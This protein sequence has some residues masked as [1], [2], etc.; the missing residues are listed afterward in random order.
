MRVSVPADLAGGRLDRIVAVVGAVS[1]SAA[2]DLI[3]AGEV[4]CDGRVV[5]LPRYP[6]EGGSEVAFELPPELPGLQPEEVGFGVAF[7]DEHLAIVDKP[8][9]VVTHPGGGD[10]GVTLAAG[11]LHRWPQVR[12]VGDTDRWGIVHRLDRDTSGLLVV[13]LTIEAHAALRAEIKARR[14][15]REYLALVTG[16][17]AIPSGTVDA[18]LGRDPRRP[19]RVRIDPQGR[20]ARTHYA[21][22][23]SFGDRALLRVTL[24][25]GRTHQIRVHLASI[26]LPVAGDRGYGSGAGSPRMFL[27]AARLAF[28]HPI[29]GQD[30]DVASPLPADL[31]AVLDELRRSRPAT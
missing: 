26:G 4:T 10:T 30:L 3:V 1:R 6:V 27:H 8:P 5:T 19:T 17:P 22:Q 11:I 20:E 23:E 21:V 7:A 9:G 24:D 25:T 29:T 2:R 16:D 12:G 14:V 28:R 15:T 31:A 18:P 13:A